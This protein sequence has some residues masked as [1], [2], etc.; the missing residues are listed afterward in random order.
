[1]DSASD[2]VPV[3]AQSDISNFAFYEYY[4]R[5]DE[6]FVFLNFDARN[7]KLSYE[8]AERF[9]EHLN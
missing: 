1:M 2:F 6:G 4:S 9:L 3:V 7:E 5:R 8:N